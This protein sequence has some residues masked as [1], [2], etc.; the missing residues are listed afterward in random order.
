MR[1]TYEEYT[2][3]CWAPSVA[4]IA[5]PTVA[6]LTAGIDVTG[7]VGKDGLKMGATNNKV[8]NDDITTAFMAELPGSYGNSLSLKCFLDD[9]DD[10]AWDTFG[11]RNTEGYLV[12]RRMIPYPTAFAAAQKVEVYH[13]ATGQPVIGDS[14]E[15]ERV[16]F[17]VDLMISEPPQMSAVVAT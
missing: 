1:H 3:I 17:T 9:A 8:K 13:G 6:E 7:F 11:T 4:D 15:N 5:A 2:R 16:A 10:D 12:I 14:A